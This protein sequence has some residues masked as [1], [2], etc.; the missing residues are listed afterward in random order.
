METIPVGLVHL[1]DATDNRSHTWTG[2]G[3]LRGHYKIK[4][5]PYESTDCANTE[6]YIEIPDHEE[7]ARDSGPWEELYL[8][9]EHPSNPELILVKETQEQLVDGTYTKIIRPKESVIKLCTLA[10]NLNDEASEPRTD[11]LRPL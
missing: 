3:R 2:I 8:H 4:Y 6:G 7:R 9:K 11:I 1:S 10:F 5:G